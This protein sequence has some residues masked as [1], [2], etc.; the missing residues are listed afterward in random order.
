MCGI[1]TTIGTALD[2]CADELPWKQYTMRR[3]GGH[4]PSG[5][6]CSRE[7]STGVG[8]G[9][10]PQTRC[11]FQCG[12]N[13]GKN[14]DSRSSRSGCATDIQNFSDADPLAFR[15]MGYYY[16]PLDGPTTAFG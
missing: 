7:W 11:T 4:G 2:L 12:Y 1:Q 14:R 3:A 10:G 5:L 9:A 6:G 15:A 13:T 8:T 16:G